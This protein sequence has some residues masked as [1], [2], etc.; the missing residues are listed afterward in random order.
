VENGEVTLEEISLRGQANATFNFGIDEI[1]NFELEVDASHQRAS[2]ECIAWDLKNQKLTQASKA[3]TFDLS[4]GNLAAASLAN[5]VGGNLEAL[6]STVPLAPKVLQAW[7]DGVMVRS[8]MAMIRGHLTVRGFGKIHCLDLVEVTGIG[9]RFNGKTPV[10]GIRHR[11]DM[12]GWQTNLQFGLSPERFAARRDIIDIPAAGLLPAVNGLQIGIVDQFEDD[13]DQEFRAKVI[14]PSVD[15]KK[16]TVWARLAT[17]EAGKERGYFFRPEPGDEVV[18]GFFNDDPG[19]AVILGAMYGSKNVP[20][21]DMA[22]LSQDNLQKGIV[23]KSGLTLGFK[24]D[25]KPS[26][27]LQT[28]GENKI[29]LDDDG[30]MIQITDQHGNSIQLGK[31]GIVIK[32]AKDLKIEASGNVEIKGSKVD[33]K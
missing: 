25:K 11:V 5:E 20:P 27:F 23:S 1:Y 13:P 29:I 30:E 14:L 6:A 8:R 2:V 22:E 26:V 24:D 3:K 32:S 7:A 33:V 28:P 12:N 9:Q 18:V 19:Q 17:P 4:Q 31:D 16:G 10:T 15:E 21:K